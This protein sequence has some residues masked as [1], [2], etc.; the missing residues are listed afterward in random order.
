MKYSFDGYNWLVS[1]EKGEKL[2]ENL[3]GLIDKEKIKGGWVSA[4]GAAISAEL[5]YYDLKEQE[6]RW[7]KVDEIMEITSLQGNIAWKDEKPILH[8]H[9]TFSKADLSC[10]GGHVKDLVV[11]GTCEVFIHRWYDEKITRSKNTKVGLDLLD[12]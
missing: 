10:V 4:I 9:G 6:Y 5:G 11:G 7:H 1:L 8:L 12:V 2:M 3:I